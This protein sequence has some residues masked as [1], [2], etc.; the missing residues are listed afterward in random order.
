MI[1]PSRESW[2]DPAKRSCRGRSPTATPRRPL[3]LHRRCCTPRPP[4][5][6]LGGRHLTLTYLATTRTGHS[7]V[8]AVLAENPSQPIS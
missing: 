1:L 7:Y 6:R 8:V 5:I 3:H 4:L 2:T